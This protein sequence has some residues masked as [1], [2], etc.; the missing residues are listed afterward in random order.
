MTHMCKHRAR[1]PRSG[2]PD[3]I[4]QSKRLGLRPTLSKPIEPQT[5]NPIELPYRVPTRETQRS[6]KKGSPGVYGTWVWVRVCVPPISSAESD[7]LAVG[8]RGIRCCALASVL[9]LFTFGFAVYR[10][11]GGML[12]GR[13]EG[14]EISLSRLCW[15]VRREV[16]DGHLTWFLPR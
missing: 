2:F 11:S 8:V 5:C 13:A 14:G 10:L 6:I 7:R 16:L 4:T 9:L 12:T 1:K 3:W 15:S